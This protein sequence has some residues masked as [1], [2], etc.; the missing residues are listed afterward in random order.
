MARDSYPRGR[1]QG[2]GCGCGRARENS[3]M[4]AGNMGCEC[5]S[6]MRKLQQ[7]DFSL[8]E[9][10]LYLDAYPDCCQALA[11]YHRLLAEREQV[12]ARYEEICGPVSCGG[13]ISQTSWD[14]VKNPWP[15]QVDF[16]G[17]GSGKQG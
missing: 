6:L 13:N 15:W 10:V 2:N 3:R 7:L 12:V 9:T 17:N 16:P 5:H 8:Q 4:D 1:Q 11:H 14:W